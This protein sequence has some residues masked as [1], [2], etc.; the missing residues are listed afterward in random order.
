MNRIVVKTGM[1]VGLLFFSLFVVAQRVEKE[2]AGRSALVWMHAYGM[3]NA[4]IGAIDELE[5]D[6]LRT[7]YIVTIDP[8]GF[9][10]LPA[11]KNAKPVL[12]Y[13]T[14]SGTND[15]HFNPSARAWIDGYS[16]Y[17]K[18]LI[19]NHIVDESA[20]AAWEDL[21]QSRIR[22]ERGKSVSPLITTKWGQGTFYNTDC[23]ADN[24]G[25]DGHVYTGCVATAMAQVMKYHNFPEHGTGEHSYV[26]PVY[27]TLYANFGETTYGWDNM[28][29][30]L[31]NYND[32]VALLMSHCGIGSN[33]NYSPTGSGTSMEAATHALKNYFNYH[34]SAQLRHKDDVSNDV[35][36]S[37]LKGELDEARPVLYAGYSSYG[38]H[39]FVCDG[40]N[41]ANMFH[42]NWGWTGSSDGYFSVT[43]VNGFNSNQQIV[44]PLFPGS[45]SGPH[46]ILKSG[47]DLLNPNPMI[48]GESVVLPLQVQN[49]GMDWNG[50][51]S[52]GVYGLDGTF[53]GEIGEKQLLIGAGVQKTLVFFQDEVSFPEGEY[54]LKVV[55]RSNCGDE[56][57]LIDAGSYVN[58]YHVHVILPGVNYAPLLSTPSVGQNGVETA[59][60]MVANA[61]WKKADFQIVYT[62]FNGDEPTVKKLLLSDDGGETYEEMT[63]N[64]STGNIST[65]KLFTKTVY[66]GDDTSAYSG[67][68]Y[69]YDFA[70]G[71][72]A[73]GGEQGIA[74]NIPYLNENETPETADMGGN[75]EIKIKY[76]HEGGAFPETAVVWVKKPQG[77]W[78]N[79]TMNEGEGEINTGK[80][81]VSTF[82]PDIPG[83]WLYRFDFLGGKTMALGSGRIYSLQISAPS[84][85]VE[86]QIDEIRIAPNP[87]RNRLY[88]S[89]AM[90][91]RYVLFDMLGGNVKEARCEGD[92]IVEM[93][94]LKPGVYLMKIYAQGRDYSRKILKY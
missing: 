79:Y 10:I 75:V 90:P 72:S 65:G 39:A 78:Q 15:L 6:G 17:V 74:Y 14:E 76:H 30:S 82:S 66:F 92:A 22:N 28:P 49:I 77:D 55:S 27:G 59:G 84:S 63:M 2:E 70:D 85:V 89:S 32:D 16:R 94:G 9:V 67:W 24:G 47:L 43:D 69:Q 93:K 88:I 58:P 18:N 20:R 48:A 61:N 60:N 26:H 1:L 13:S 46:L 71:E 51:I 44:I 29:N 36:I 8:L 19:E 40:Y 31:Y 91:F 52:L 33:M 21:L 54:L 34:Y 68:V 7:L 80:Y 56:E 64:A 83:T 57:V 81:F 41:D 23:P 3:K 5:E 45:E 86:N 87:V 50:C 37:M 42:F 25:P 73:A 35:W 53:V 38:G 4:K 62:D 12:A 11:D